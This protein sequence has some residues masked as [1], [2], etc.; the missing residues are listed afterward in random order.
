MTAD[1]DY[2][3]H[4]SYK[5]GYMIAA[6]KTAIIRLSYEGL[7]NDDNVLIN[8]IRRELEDA[9]SFIGEE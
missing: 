1:I 9:L 6:A 2:T 5:L 7:T 3:T 4:P 8:A